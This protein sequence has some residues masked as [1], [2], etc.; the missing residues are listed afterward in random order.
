MRYETA[1]VAGTRF[2]YNFNGSLE[3]DLYIVRFEYGRVVDDTTDL[4][5]NK[6]I[7]F[8]TD[9][10]DI[11]KEMFILKQYCIDLGYTQ[12]KSRKTHVITQY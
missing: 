1:T 7:I 5:F 10:E 6:E 3:G 12:T 8:C 4:Q 2:Y 9:M 11:Q